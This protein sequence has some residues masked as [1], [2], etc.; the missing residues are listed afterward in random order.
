MFYCCFLLFS[1]LIDAEY[2]P[3]VPRE[4]KTARVSKVYFNICFC[5][6]LCRLVLILNQSFFLPGNFT[7]QSK[8]EKASGATTC[9]GLFSSSSGH[10]GKRILYCFL[11]VC[12][13]ILVLLTTAYWAVDG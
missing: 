13:H 12:I 10:Q 1:V 9:M 8:V 5:F 2:D 6:P 11:F 4:E 3:L 7:F